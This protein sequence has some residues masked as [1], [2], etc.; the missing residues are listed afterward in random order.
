MLLTVKLEKRVRPTHQ[1][2]LMPMSIQSVF[3]QLLLSASEKL[4]NL[5]ERLGTRVT[6]QGSTIGALS[7]GVLI[8]DV[9]DGPYLRE[10]FDEDVLYEDGIPEYLNAMLVVKI[11]EDGKV[12]NVNFWYETEEEAMEIKQYFNSN[13]KPLEVM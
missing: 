2:K 1:R 4:R 7:S 10:E 12:G 8:W 9:I 11:E 5:A 3:G 6:G 13:I